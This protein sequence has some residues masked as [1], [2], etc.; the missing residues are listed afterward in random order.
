MLKIFALKHCTKLDGLLFRE[1]LSFLDKQEQ[2]KI[3]KFYRWQDA[4]RSLLGSLIIRATICDMF[5]VKNSDIE[6][7]RNEMGKPYI[8]NMP[9]V[10]FNISHSGHWIVGAFD[11]FP[12]GI[13]IEKIKASDFDVVKSI[14]AA[15]DYEEMLKIEVPDQMKYFYKCWTMGESYQKMLGSGVTLPLLSTNA[16]HDTAF[17]NDYSIDEE[18]MLSVCSSQGVFP[19]GI[20]ITDTEQLLN[21]IR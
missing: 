8:N 1:I 12:I 2:E 10:F 4:E 15:D 6:V 21:Q 18:Y 3:L 17:F 20:V 16:L 7:F 5:Q 19:E 9:Q 13:D 11:S 14:L